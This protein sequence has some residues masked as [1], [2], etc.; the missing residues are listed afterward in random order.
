VGSGRSSSQQRPTRGLRGSAPERPTVVSLPAPDVGPM[1][2]AMADATND[3]T[4]PAV[5]Q[6]LED[7]ATGFNSSLPGSEGS[8]R[9]ALAARDDRGQH[10]RDDRATRLCFTAS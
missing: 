8:C 9:V 10:G 6:W 3:C 5:V 1:N 2:R 4:I 7:F